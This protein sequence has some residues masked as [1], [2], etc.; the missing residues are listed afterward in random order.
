MRELLGKFDLLEINGYKFV[1]PMTG[2]MMSHSAVYEKK[3]QKVVVKFL[4][5]PR[6]QKEVKHFEHEVKNI[7]RAS[8]LGGYSVK[9]LSDLIK[10][11]DFPIY[12]FISEYYDGSTLSD[13]LSKNDLP[14]PIKDAISMLRRCAIVLGYVSA[15]GVIHKDFHAGNI[16]VLSGDKISDG[17]P[18]IRLIDFGLSDNYIYG[19]YYG[20]LNDEPL[21]HF[22]AISSWSPEYL[23]DSNSISTSH[24]IWALGV[25]FFRMVTGKWAFQSNSFGEYYQKVCDGAYDQILLNDVTS[26]R[27]VKHLVRRMFDINTE[28][29]IK[30]GAIVHMCDDYI[31]GTTAKL[32]NDKKLENLYYKYDADI[33]TCP[34]CHQIVHPE[35]VICPMC[36]HRD[37]E[38]MPI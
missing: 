23:R 31:N 6:N 38:F 16:I 4:L 27:I 17:D 2:G 10:H 35:G 7:H 11:P 19:L 1:E 32:V 8:T 9:L 30:Q 20:E 3:E 22:G 12:Y 37:D 21:R 33:A 29:R 18:G 28:T 13:Y 24:D 15:L 25:L 14:L 36:G 34:H 26:E 5:F